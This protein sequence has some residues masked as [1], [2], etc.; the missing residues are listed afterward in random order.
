MSLEVLERPRAVAPK[1]PENE[2]GE[3]TAILPEQSLPR[4]LFVPR[5]E[6]H[7]LYER[8]R[9]TLAGSGGEQIVYTVPQFPKQV[10]K[11][12]R[13]I[14]QRT[15]VQQ[16]GVIPDTPQKEKN[17]LRA[18]EGDVLG[19]QEAYKRLERHFE[20]RHLLAERVTKMRLP[21]TQDLLQD[22]FGDKAPIVPGGMA[23]LPFVVRIQEKVSDRILEH[24]L[25]ASSGYAEN[26][27]SESVH[28][29]E[30][31]ASGSIRWLSD[32][33]SETPFDLDL[34]LQCQGSTE[35]ASL[36]ERAN[37]DNDLREAVQDFVM[38]AVEFTQTEGQIL[39]LAGER[40]VVFYQD[41]TSK[42]WSYLLIDASFPD[43]V[44]G[45]I[46]IATG[47]LENY[48]EHQ[49]LEEVELFALLNA[50][51][52]ARTINGLADA[53]GMKERINLLQNRYVTIDPRVIDW[54]ELRQHLLMQIKGPH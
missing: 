32:S 50:L 39:D 40:N 21:V 43:R 22:C 51:N 38:R 49:E 52:Y 45:R 31:Y 5:R 29:Q 1:V 10:I 35:L 9:P 13:R 28:D 7:R 48:L 37:Q 17:L 12:S 2:S 8:Y 53:L 34:F 23:N 26:R 24:G 18:L 44:K 25:D 16:K 41:E 30:N 15:L 33:P 19:E 4:A 42:S 47:A 27:V 6:D 46:D 14:L 20:R 36:I 11:V 54:N 3:V